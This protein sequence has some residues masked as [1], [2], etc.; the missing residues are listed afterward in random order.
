MHS[1]EKRDLKLG[2]AAIVI[3]S[4]VYSGKMFKKKSVD[5]KLKE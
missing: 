3:I 4:F 1:V 5:S 2:K